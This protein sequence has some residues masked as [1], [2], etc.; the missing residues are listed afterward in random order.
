ML[1]D[2]TLTKTITASSETLEA[3]EITTTPYVTPTQSG[4]FID[5]HTPRSG[6]QTDLIIV[7]LILTVMVLI[8]FVILIAI[9]I[10]FVLSWKGNKS[11]A[12][13]K[14]LSSQNNVGKLK[15][16]FLFIATLRLNLH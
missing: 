11:S 5:D 6:D 7:I 10:T 12:Y 9:L 15:R 14:I 13:T 4:S 1:L 16:L 3:V 8:L 2:S